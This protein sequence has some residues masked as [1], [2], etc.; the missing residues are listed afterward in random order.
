MA[1]PKSPIPSLEEFRSQL[2]RHKLRA[3]RQRLAV[4]EVM[5]TLVHASADMVQEQLEQSG[6][7][8]TAASVYNILSQLADEHIYNRRL[9]AAGKMYFDIDPSWHIHLYDRERHTFRNLAD[10]QLSDLVNA[11]L[12]RRRFRGYT[13]EGVDIQIIV[14]PTNKNKKK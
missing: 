9:A 1:K 7:H 6:S 13:I 4:H 8:V 12:R 2:R 3:T 14:K 11:L 10:E 5:M